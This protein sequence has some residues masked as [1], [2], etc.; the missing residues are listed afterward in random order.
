M[1]NRKKTFRNKKKHNKKNKS[2]RRVSKRNTR[3]MRGGDLKDN[4]YYIDSENIEE[5][6]T[7]L[8]NLEN[9]LVSATVFKDDNKKTEFERVTKEEINYIVE[10]IKILS[11]PKT[12]RIMNA[13]TN[14]L[15]PKTV[16]RN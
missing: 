6:K 8:T 11:Q 1:A 16:L 3:K 10:R 13:A 7:R 15:M 5:L 9:L 2:K 14:F 4:K 12:T